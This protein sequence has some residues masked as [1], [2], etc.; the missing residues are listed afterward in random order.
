MADTF[1]GIITADGKKRQ[2][3]YSA[4]V[5]VPVSDKTLSEEDGF[6]DSKVVG[7]KFAKVDSETA[8]LKEDL[9]NCINGLGVA[10]NE[11]IKFDLGEFIIGLYKSD[12]TIDTTANYSVC[13]NKID[14]I[15]TSVIYYTGT[16]RYDTQFGIV[17]FDNNDNVVGTALNGT[18]DQVLYTNELIKVPTKATKVGLSFY[19]VDQGNRSL[20]GTRTNIKS[21]DSITKDEINNLL[22]YTVTGKYSNSDLIS[23]KYVDEN[24]VLEEQAIYL[25]TGIVSCDGIKYYKYNGY[26]KWAVMYAYIFL[27]DKGNVIAKGIEGT[28]KETYYAD[29]KIDVPTSAKKVAFNFLNVY[30][31]ETRFVEYV[32]EKIGT[33]DDKIGEYKRYKNKKW[34]CVGDSLTQNNDATKTHYFDY[35]SQEYGF[36]VVNMGVGGTGYMRGHDTN[37]AF[38][39]RISNCPTDADVVTI[40]GSGNDLA[41]SDK[42]GDYSDSGVDTICG[43]INK[44]IDNYFSVCPTKPIGI[45]APCPW[46]DYP[47]TTIGNAMERYVEKLKKIS[48]YRGIPFLDL[49]HSSNLRPE[50]ETNRNACFYN[51][52]ELDG[53]GDGV[54]P[55]ELG[56]KIISSK[57]R[58]FLLTLIN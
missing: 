17:F 6:A 4:V 51:R 26:A 19:N 16:L 27:D 38:Y 1:K 33:L 42:L 44:T 36:M 50:N 55:N 21:V 52:A 2:L 15:G 58:E 39:Q 28:E 48:E 54:H 18:G 10:E 56:H 25:T 20:T 30:A 11:T 3:P 9:D 29:Q 41:L 24:G 57:I 47:T 13:T 22:K 43:C 35:I 45:I 31:S 14:I 7:D 12:G 8:S 53:N 32:Q 49:Y 5:E 46:R 34:V 37:N 40:F 23:G